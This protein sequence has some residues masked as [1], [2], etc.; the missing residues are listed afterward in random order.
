MLL[1]QFFNETHEQI[2]KS[3]FSPFLMKLFHSDA[4]MSSDDD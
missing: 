4:V 1:K 3:Y 2:L